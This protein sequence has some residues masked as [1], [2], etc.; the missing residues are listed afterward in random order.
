M[1]VN[2]KKAKYQ[3][4]AQCFNYF[5]HRQ[6]GKVFG[7]VCPSVRPLATFRKNY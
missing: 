7:S 6:G 4:K 3:S 1:Q 2:Y 5:Y